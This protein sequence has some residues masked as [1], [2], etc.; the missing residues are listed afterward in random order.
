MEIDEVAHWSINTQPQNGV[1][2]VQKRIHCSTFY[3]YKASAIKEAN[4]K[5]TAG[6]VKNGKRETIKSQQK[7]KKKKKYV[8]FHFLRT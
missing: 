7:G 4:L 8:K 6:K 5:Q 2:T 1:K 3:S